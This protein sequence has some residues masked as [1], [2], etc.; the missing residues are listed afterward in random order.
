MRGDVVVVLEPASSI[1]VTAFLTQEE[2]LK[3]KTGDTASVFIPAL[4]QSFEAHIKSI[5]RRLSF[6]NAKDEK[7]WL[8]A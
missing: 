2:I 6:V 1:K 4:D 3:L 5:N 7:L 8:A